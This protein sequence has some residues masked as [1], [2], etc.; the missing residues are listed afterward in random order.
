MKSRIV[1]VLAGALILFPG[2]LLAQ[3]H[4]GGS[5]HGGGGMMG[6]NQY[7]MGQGEGVL[8]ASNSLSR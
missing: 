3:T 8:W 7:M 1:A 4:R 2:V 5:M 6:S